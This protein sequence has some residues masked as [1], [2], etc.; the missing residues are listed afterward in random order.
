MS[1]SIPSLFPKPF[2][3]S[4][5]KNVIPDA[6]ASP[7]ASLTDGFPPVTMQPI[8]AGG[9][10]PAGEDFN[11]ILYWIT[12]HLQWM[13]SGM[14]YPFNSALSTALGG[15][16][17]GAVVVLDDFSA[18]V[19]SLADNN[20]HDPNN[21]ANLG[22]YWAPWA[23]SLAGGH[24]SVDTGAKNAYVVTANPPI[25]DYVDGLHVSF[26]VTNSNDAASTLN[27]GGGAADIKR[28]D[29]SA[30]QSGD[31]MAGSIY[32]VVYDA[33]SGDFYLTAP[34]PSQY[35]TS[36]PSGTVTQFAG[37]SVP[38]G[39][40]ECNGAAVSRA[41]YSSLFAAIGTTWGIGDGSTTFNLPDARGRAPIGVGTGSGLTARVLGTSGGAETHQ[42]VTTELPSHTHTIAGE[43]AESGPGD[44]CVNDAYTGSG[45][46]TATSNA[47]GSD[48][49][50]NNMQPWVAFKFIIKT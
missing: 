18:A 6:S 24:Y 31:L 28:N 4:G 22:V 45:T 11:G 2:A 49:A 8:S 30:V 1:L 43:K 37:A 12:Q 46:W 42:L 20:T 48:V 39:W 25:A 32:T 10:P 15:Y 9:V 34:V 13:N 3:A 19:V 14:I 5:S 50:H 29:G 40:L 41:T 23:G 38:A 21:P 16:N 27:A 47:T 26:K 7:L 33:T 44:P 36:T 35:S 17:E